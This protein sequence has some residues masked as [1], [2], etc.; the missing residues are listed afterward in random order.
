MARIISDMYVKEDKHIW[1]ND[2]NEE[3]NKRILAVN[4]MYGW[5]YEKG[6]LE[7]VSFEFRDYEDAAYFALDAKDLMPLRRQMEASGCQNASLA[8][9]HI[10]DES[11]TPCTYSGAIELGWT[12]MSYRDVDGCVGRSWE[13]GLVKNL[14]SEGIY[15]VAR[16]RD[17]SGVKAAVSALYAQF[18]WIL[19]LPEQKRYQEAL[20][21]FSQKAGV[22]IET[23]Y[24]KTHARELIYCFDNNK[25]LSDYDFWTRYETL[26]SEKMSYEEYIAVDSLYDGDPHE[27]QPSNSEL[28]SA[29]KGA[30]NHLRNPDS[31]LCADISNDNLFTCF[32]DKGF[33]FLVRAVDLSDAE[34]AGEQW[35]T[36]AF[37]EPG[38]FSCWKTEI[39]D[40]KQLDSDHVVQSPAYL[41][42]IQ[43]AHNKISLNDAIRSASDRLTEQNSGPNV[44]LGDPER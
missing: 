11:Y 28:I 30:L 14:D 29:L 25:S 4:E 20:Q 37:F 34:K 40:F 42:S 41:E 18:D 36:S 2:P 31:I 17:E 6:I 44:M 32:A 23:D 33:K 19:T 3:F 26:F 16:V 12:M 38:H 27:I 15:E 35:Y 22:N 7:K 24:V 43:T 9:R 13:C 8:T 10:F 1:G 39:D 5:L 21:H